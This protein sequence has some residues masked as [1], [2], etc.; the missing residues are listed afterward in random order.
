MATEPK[1]ERIELRMSPLEASMLRELADDGRIEG[2]HKKL[3][4]AGTLPSVVL[5]EVTGRDR[6]GDARQGFPG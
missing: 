3:H 5:A 4:H 2:R 6:D 1:T